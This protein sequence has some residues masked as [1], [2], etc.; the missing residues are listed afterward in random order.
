MLA[1]LYK[2]GFVSNRHVKKKSTKKVVR[3]AWGYQ[4]CLHINNDTNINIHIDINMT[5]DTTPPAPPPM[6]GPPADG[7]RAG[8]MGWEGGYQCSY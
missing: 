8:C 4:Y 6:P 5:V 3:G 2:N 7:A 1:N